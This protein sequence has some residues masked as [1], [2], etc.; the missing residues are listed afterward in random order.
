LLTLSQF[1]I[2]IGTGR[3]IN[4]PAKVAGEPASD[5]EQVGGYM[6]FNPA[7]LSLREPPASLP[8]GSPPNFGGEFP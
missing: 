2:K 5:S 7:R 8:L 1:E 3:W 4:S 6:K